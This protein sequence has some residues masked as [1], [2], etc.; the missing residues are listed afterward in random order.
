MSLDREREQF[1]RRF[2]VREEKLFSKLP[3]GYT[4]V[5]GEAGEGRERCRRRATSRREG[6]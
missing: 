1:L 4:V 5:A 3:H 2:A 6:A